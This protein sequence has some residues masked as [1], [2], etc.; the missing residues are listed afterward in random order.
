M[1][2][3]NSHCWSINLCITCELNQAEKILSINS[4][5]SF[6]FFTCAKMN[7]IINHQ[8]FFLF[9]DYSHRYA[10]PSVPHVSQQTLG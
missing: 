10:V 9:L 8:H 5:V 4:D 2:Q 7:N 1:F 3:V 6:N